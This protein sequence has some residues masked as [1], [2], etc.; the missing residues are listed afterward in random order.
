M[1]FNIRPGSEMK[2]VAGPF[3]VIRDND[4]HDSLNDGSTIDTLRARACE[5]TR[6][7]AELPTL[8]F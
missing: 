7:Q 1:D 6:S 4:V 5:T 3:R 8:T 2:P